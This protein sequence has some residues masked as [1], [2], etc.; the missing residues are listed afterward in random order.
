MIS[1]VCTTC[2]TRAMVLDSMAGQ[3]GRCRKCGGLVR[4]PGG[5]KKICGVCG[6]DVSDAQRVKDAEGK[7]LCAACHQA[8]LAVGQAPEMSQIYV[9]SVCQGVFSAADVYDDAGKVVCKSCWAGNAAPAGRPNAS[10]LIC[11]K[12]N[13]PGA[14]DQMRNL[15]GLPFCRKCYGKMK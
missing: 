10:M 8:Q 14:Y 1:V 5:P 9:C 6:K 15:N 4:V 13:T 11:A 2:G 7:Y 12:C 3:K